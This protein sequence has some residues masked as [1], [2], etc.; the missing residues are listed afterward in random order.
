MAPAFATGAEIVCN[1]E[2]GGVGFVIPSHPNGRRRRVMAIAVITARHV[3]QMGERDRRAEFRAMDRESRSG[4][5]G[6]TSPGLVMRNPERT[7]GQ[8]IV[9]DGV[10]TNVRERDGVT[11]MRVIADIAARERFEVV[12]PVVADQG[13]VS[14]ARVRVY[15]IHVDTEEVHSSM[16]G[17]IPQ[18]VIYAVAAVALDGA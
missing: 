14:G 6:Y 7:I 4:R 5:D 11:S 12:L 16:H 15:G 8:M 13:V 2:D 10:A 17:D 9:L 18:P 3:S 1:T